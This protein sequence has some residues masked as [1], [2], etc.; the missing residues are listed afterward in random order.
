MRRGV[1]SRIRAAPSGAVAA[2]IGHGNE[3]V[4]DAMIDGAPCTS[5][6]QHRILDVF[7][8]EAQRVHPSLPT[9]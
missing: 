2:N 8:R 4:C 3:R 1:R 5:Q 7:Q 9:Y 6:T